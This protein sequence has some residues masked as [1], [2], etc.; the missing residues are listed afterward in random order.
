MYMADSNSGPVGGTRLP[1]RNKQVTFEEPD[2]SNFANQ[3]QQP[4]QQQPTPQQIPQQYQPPP[5]PQQQVPQQMNS[6]A[7]LQKTASQM[8]ARP[9]PAMVPQPA[10]ASEGVVSK[11]GSSMK[12]SSNLKMAIIVSVI[13]VLLNSKIVWKQILKLPYMGGL[14]PSMLAL[15]VNSMLAG[16]IFFIINKFVLKN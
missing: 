3:Q 8:A 15:V 1:P 9:Q 7:G 10:M 5:P 6:S 14:E 2:K 4:R 16:I 13:F 12:A 11:F